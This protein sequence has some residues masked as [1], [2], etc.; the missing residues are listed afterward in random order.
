MS[1]SRHF[2]YTIR[3]IRVEILTERLTDRETSIFAQHYDY[4]S[5]LAAQ[6]VVEF[7]GRTD[8]DNESTFGIVVFHAQTEEDARKIML[9]DPVVAEGLM[10]P[11]LFPFRLSI[12]TAQ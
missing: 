5:E 7:A 2:I 11:E 8:T 12:A 4:L 10:I 3:P 1:K 9:S 6:G